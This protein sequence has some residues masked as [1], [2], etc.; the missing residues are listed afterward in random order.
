MAARFGAREVARLEIVYS[1]PSISAQRARTRAVLD[2]RPGERGLDV[3]CGPAFLACELGRDV[4]PAGRIVGIDE[5][6][7]M[8]RAARARIARTEMAD[9]VEVRQADAARLAFPDAAFDFVTA[10]AGLS[11]RLRR[12]GRAGRS[13]ARPAPGG[14]LA[15]LDTDW[16]S[17]VWLTADRHRHRRVMEKR[18]AYFVQPHL[19]ARLPGLLGRAGLELARAEAI[20]LLELD[21]G[22]ETFSGGLIGPTADLAARHG[23]PREDCG[24]LAV[25]SPCARRRRRVLLQLDAV[26]VRREAPDGL[27]PIRGR[28][29]RDRAGLGERRDLGRRELEDLGQHLRR[30]LAEKRGGPPDR[31]RCGRRSEGEAQHPHAPVVRLVRRLRHFGQK[32]QVPN[33]RVVEDLVQL[34]D[35]APAIEAASKRT[36][37]SVVVSAARAVSTRVFISSWFSRRP[38]LVEKRGSVL[39]TS[40]P[41][42][43]Q[44]RSHCSRHSSGRR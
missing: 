27:T 2:A 43:R 12:R 34:V 36:T 7:E 39:S 22:P 15:V 13:R 9:R 32:A 38:R 8:L 4:G 10:V 25:G 30:V 20:P 44:K 11:L 28:R 18:S 24:G 14:R 29:E 31:R 23:V 41:S 37:H 17:C 16:D 40:S 42:T 3:G 33:L 1:S 26:P 21:G 5:S 19:P 35:Q 6:P